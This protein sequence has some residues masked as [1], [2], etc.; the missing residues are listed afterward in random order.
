MIK[1]TFRFFVCT[2]SLRNGVLVY[3]IVSYSF[4]IPTGWSRGKQSI[5]ALLQNIAKAV[6]GD[7]LYHD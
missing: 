6:Y 1:G 4:I 7:D 5:E 2:L 3:V